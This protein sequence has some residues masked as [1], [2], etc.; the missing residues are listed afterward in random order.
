MKTQSTT[1]SGLGGGV[2]AIDQGMVRALVIVGEREALCLDSGAA[3]ADF[4]ALLAGVTDR[5]VTFCLTHSDRDHTANLAAFGQVWAHPAELPY[6]QGQ[7]GFDPG[8]FRPAEAG[9]VFDLGGTRLEVLHVPGHTPGSIALLDREGGRLFS[10]DTVS[11]GPV[12]LFG[13]NRDPEQ[14]RQSLERLQ[15][16]ADG[17]AYDT[18]YPCH[19]ACPVPADILPELRACLDGI[20]RGTASG[21]PAGLTMPGAEAVRL[22]RA[23]RCGIYH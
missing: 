2:W 8:K 17:G 16:L 21:E 13:P 22:Y 1:V 4:P 10:G 20:L 5:P 6:L 23:G 14:Y 9:R 11:L 3:P 15:A 18:V 7:P 12:F 19:N